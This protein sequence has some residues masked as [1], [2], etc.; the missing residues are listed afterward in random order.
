MINLIKSDFYKLFRSKGFYICTVLSIAFAFITL[1]ISDFSYNTIENVVNTATSPEAQES[2]S[3]LLGEK[4]NMV[5]MFPD[6][7]VSLFLSVFISI[8]V[9]LFIA[10]DFS[11]GVI[12]NI[13]SKVS[14]RE[15][16]FFSKFITAIFITFVILVANF[17]TF[18]FGSLALWGFCELP[19]N[20]YPELLRMCGL[21]F[22]AF[23]AIT[24]VFT[25]ISLLVEKTGGAIA[26]NVCI[27]Y[28]SGIILNLISLIINKVLKSEF[29]INDY[30]VFDYPNA[31]ASYTLETDVIVRCS[32]VSVATIAIMTLL[33]I[34]LMRRK[35]IK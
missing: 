1:L 9:S 19:Q 21:E 35:E 4:P 5:N 18:L 27:L 14:R 6:S 7:F 10:Q 33:G 16:I 12:K 34:L 15:Y 31:L 11:S 20:F 23:I 26:I 22:L 8:A 3:E 29:S 25:I 30:W 28:L 24:S 17:I 32:L 13:V 2:F